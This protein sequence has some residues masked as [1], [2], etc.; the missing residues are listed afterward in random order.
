VLIGQRDLA[1]RRGRADVLKRETRR[2]EQPPRGVVGL[3]G[4]AADRLQQ[5]PDGGRDGED[6]CDRV[7]LANRERARKQRGVL[8]EPGQAQ[9]VVVR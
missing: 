5:R 9:R 7:M 2:G 1:V 4:E 3:G 6:G 8:R